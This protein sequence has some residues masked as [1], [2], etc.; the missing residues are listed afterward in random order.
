MREKTILSKTLAAILGLAMTMSTLP[1]TAFAAKV[2]LPTGMSKVSDDEQT[3]APGIT[4]NEVAFYDQYNR[5][6]RMFLVTADLSVDTVSVETSYYNDQGDVW[7]LQRLTDQVAAA[8]A[9]HA[10]ENYKVVA[11]I[12]AAFFNT[13]TGQPGGAFAINGEVHCTDAE[14]NNYPFFAILKDGTAVIDKKG[15][16]TQYKDRVAEAVQGYQMIV[17][18]GKNQLTYNPGS[19]DQTQKVY[20]RTCLGITADGKVVAIQVD[21]SYS[22]Y[23]LSLYH[24]AELMIQAGCVS[25]VRLDEGGSSTYAAREEGSDDFVVLNNPVDGQE[26]TISNGVIFVTTAAP[27][28]KFDHATIASEYAYY[29]PNTAAQFTATGVD[30]T[31]GKAEVPAE[32]EWKLSDDSFG[33]INKNGVFQSTGKLGDVAINLVY[34]NE[35]V[36]SK[37]ITVVNPEKIAFSTSSTV[38]PFGSS[39][40]LEVNATYGYHSVCVDENCF[41]LTSSEAGAGTFE[42]LKFIAAQESSVLSTV[43]YAKYKHSDIEKAQ[44]EITFGKGSDILYNF[45]NGDVSNWLGN[46]AWDSVY[47]QYSGTKP[48][49]AWVDPCEGGLRSNTFLATKENG[50]VKN[51]E[52]SLGFTLDATQNTTSGG[53]GYTHLINL[54]I[55]NNY[56]VLRDIANGNTG[57]RIGMWMYIPENAVFICPRILWSTSTD[58]GTTWKRAHSKIMMGYKEVAYDGMTDARIPE[59]GW[60]YVYADITA[61]D[62]AG[63]MHDSTQNGTN[64]LYPAFIEFI[65]HSNCKSNEK[66]TFFIDDITLDYSSIVSDRDMPIIRDMKVNS[67]TIDVAT[68]NGNTITSNNATFSAAVADDTTSS[69]VNN[70]TGLDYATA[71]IYVDGNPIGTTASAGNMISDEVILTNGMHDITFTIADNAG[72][73]QKTTKQVIVSAKDS[74]YPT[75]AVTGR[76]SDGTTPKNGSVYWLDFTASEVEKINKIDT[77][78]YL[79]GSNK[80][81]FDNIVALPGFEYTAS[82]N[83]NTHL[84]TLSLEKTG[85]VS[86]DGSA[87]VA[88]VPVRVWTNNTTIPQNNNPVINIVYDVK[89]GTVDYT[90]DVDVADNF[91]G[92]FTAAKTSVAT[93]IQGAGS[94]STYHQHNITALEDKTATCTEEGYTGRTYCEECKSVID[95]G[96]TV[97]TTG[98]KYELVD[99]QFVCVNCND[100][101]NAGSGLFEMNGKYYYAIGG[102]LQTGWVEIDGAWHYFSKDYEAVTGEYYYASRNI[103]YQ[104]DKTGKTDGVWQE[105]KAGKRFWYGQWYYT[106]RNANQCKFVEINGKTYNFDLDGYAT[107]GIQMLYAD[108]SALMRKE[109]N[110]WEFDNDGALIRKITDKGVIDNQRGDLYLVEEDGCIHTGNAHLAKYNGDLYFVLHSGRLRKNGTQQITA[111]NSNGLYESGTYEFDADGKM[112]T[113][114]G[115]KADASGTLY[116]YKNGQIGSRIYNNELV[117]INGSI[118]LVKWSGKVAANEVREVSEAQANGLVEAGTYEFD[119]DGKLFKGTGVKADASGTLYYYRDG[120]I[121]SRIY[122]SML[123]E[124]DGSIYLVKWSGKVAANEVRE[125]SEAQANGLVEAGTYEFDA[126]GKMSKFTLTGVKADTSGTLY[127]YKDGKIGSRIYNSELVNIDGS[128]YLVKWSGKV[129]ANETRIVSESKAN[130]LLQAGTYEFGADGKLLNGTKADAS[131]TLYYY[132]DGEI[133]SRIYNNEL[134]EING[135]IYFVKWSGKVAANEV[136]EIS[137]A[138]ANGLVEAGTYEFDADGKMFSGT[139]VKADVSGILYYY[140]DGKIGS[141]IYNNELVKIDDSVY[142]VKWSGKVAANETRVVSESKTNGLVKAGTYVFGADGKLV[143]K[144]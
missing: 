101:Y 126:D 52:Y 15:T 84:L 8:E 40:D 99:G 130:G 53:W 139:G 83:E 41:T 108:W 33:T 127:Y 80:F 124:I 121:G 120:I 116:Y 115:V 119:A 47:T 82:F 94:K 5:K 20:P 63:Y 25:A 134:V 95:W 35:I 144:N 93:T 104:F 112:V 26:R 44:M 128:I 133:G 109:M 102:V 51:G 24:A 10:G 71:Q 73:L 50:Y 23:G 85:N 79:N 27:T 105:T 136:R 45:E 110:V 129:A 57:C 64:N 117:E 131:G 106:A 62:L 78:V 18:N 1:M 6:Q 86:V 21:S 74:T 54:D 2:S 103:T 61:A 140:K 135:S 81:E 122:N 7:G 48:S 55:I 29:A 19:N 9:N 123:V 89:A 141:R 3:L 97:P 39:L 96:K 30:A 114:T 49:S 90:D 34:E 70:S 17:D 13:S 100:I 58:G 68:L 67:G 12:N 59:S 87:I 65:V 4:Q 142:F 76:S 75:I 98:H 31:N 32:A 91:V 38:L 113:L 72:N 88:S 11:G 14:G 138:Q 107:T 36:G 77:T 132:K 16:W 137:E 118:Y 46:D 143:E 66:I 125:V 111:E 56:K 43:I 92:S 42:G 37:T 22:N 69:G 28:G 60:T